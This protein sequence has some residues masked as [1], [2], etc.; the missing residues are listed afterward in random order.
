MVLKL[1]LGVQVAT[2]S[3]RGGGPWCRWETSD[4]DGNSSTKTGKIL[5]ALAEL[6]RDDLL[7]V[8]D[9]YCVTSQYSKVP[10]LDDPL[11]VFGDQTTILAS[12]LA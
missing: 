2:G 6:D 12:I 1:R 10:K 3:V 7:H 4:V 5:R 8:T 9:K 11:L